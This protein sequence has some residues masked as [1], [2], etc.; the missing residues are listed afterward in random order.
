MGRGFSLFFSLFLAVILAGVFSFGVYVFADPPT[1][2]YA[3]GATLNPNCTVGST[4]CTVTAPVPY[5]GATSAVD[6]GSQS[7]ST[8][9]SVSLGSV[10]GTTINATSTSGPQANVKYDSSNYAS[11]ST[12]SNGDFT[13]STNSAT[14]GGNINLNSAVSGDTTLLGTS[15]SLVLGGSGGTNNENLKLDFETYSNKVALTS[16]TGVTDLDFGSLNLVT[17][18]TLTLGGSTTG[19]LVTR[20][21]A[22]AVTES[23][24]NGSLV[25]DSTDGRLYF[26]YGGAWH[27]VAQTA[28]F[29]IPD[30]ET[31][32]PIS[33]EQ[34]KEGDIVLGQ[35][36]QTF[37]DHALHGIWI[38]WDDVKADL[39]KE[40]QSSGALANLPQGLIGTTSP[41]DTSV[42]AST[43]GSLMDQVT[44][45]LSSLGI[46]IANGITSIANLSVQKSDTQLAK[47][48]RIEMVDQNNGDVYC[49][50]IAN[51]EWVKAKGEC[52]SVEVAVAAVSQTQQT[53]STSQII[54]Q[55]TQDLKPVIQS[56]VEQQVQ[57]AVQ[58]QSGSGDNSASGSDQ[59]QS[60]TDSGA[61]SAPSISSSSTSDT[62]AP[63]VQ[64]DPTLF[65]VIGNTFQTKSQSGAILLTIISTFLLVLALS[66]AFSLVRRRIQHRM[67]RRLIREIM[68]EEKK[69]KF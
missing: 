27:Y 39:I 23:D 6:L 56:Q 21:K 63:A 69:F 37:S 9:G 31:T 13:L 32:D 47:I 20:V 30:F 66:F 8:T 44:N 61:S 12:A 33:G 18:G 15:G 34:I 26:R 29:Q 55:V 50:W 67:M 49:T 60:S 1:T 16:S 3:P 22:G 7:F 17:T 35:I 62:S 2:P 68:E 36:N 43:G 45:V 10:T 64:G 40:L 46:S 41:S 51:G 19:T 52:D 42:V 5:T 24:T 11:L 54:S 57:D 25:V 28:G 38:K 58:A 65:D 53:P 48:N 59:T 4:N 14:T